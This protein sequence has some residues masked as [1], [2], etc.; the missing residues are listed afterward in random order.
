LYAAP[1]LTLGSLGTLAGGSV[2][3]VVARTADLQ[4]VQLSTPLGFG[5]VQAEFVT[6]GGDTGLIPVIGG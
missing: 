3:D 5:W 1:N 4:W 2:Y 6:L